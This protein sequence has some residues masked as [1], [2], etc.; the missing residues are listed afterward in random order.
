MQEQATLISTVATTRCNALPL[1]GYRA[2]MEA[3]ER[4]SLGYVRLIPVGNLPDGPQHRTA[5]SIMRG[6]LYSVEY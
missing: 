5:G 6:H 1:I 3:E 2:I 4:N